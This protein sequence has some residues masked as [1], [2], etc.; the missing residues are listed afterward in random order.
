VDDIQYKNAAA[1]LKLALTTSRG[2]LPSLSDIIPV[3]VARR[4]IVIPQLV[5]KRPISVHEAPRLEA[6]RGRMGVTSPIANIRVRIKIQ[7]LSRP[8]RRAGIIG[9]VNSFR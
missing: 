8:V 3:V 1:E 9:T 7:T 4:V 2:F 6:Y 5:P